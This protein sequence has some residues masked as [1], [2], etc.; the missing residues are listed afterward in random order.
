MSNEP[1][2]DQPADD[3]GLKTHPEHGK[4]DEIQED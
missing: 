4:P 3:D 2:P 1:A